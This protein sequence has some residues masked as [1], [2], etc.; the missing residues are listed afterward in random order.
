MKA[1]AFVSSRR[2]SFN[3]RASHVAPRAQPRGPFDEGAA[4]VANLLKRDEAELTGKVGIGQQAYEA[5]GEEA[6]EDKLASVEEFPDAFKPAAGG[7]VDPSQVKSR[8]AA[9]K[10]RKAA[11]ASPFGDATLSPSASPFGDASSLDRGVEP[12][13]MSPTM[14]AD[15]INEAPW[16]T[17]IT[18][19][20]IFLFFTFSSMTLS[21]LATVYVVMKTGAIH[22]NDDN[23]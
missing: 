12:S 13:K 4:Q 5:F 7:D 2:C 11:P 19:G 1:T 20:Q 21:M 6:G 3:R 8:K 15:P 18:P 17:R 14:D 9:L 16:W 10:A 22:F 23:Y